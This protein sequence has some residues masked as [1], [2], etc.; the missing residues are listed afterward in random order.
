M[1]H[2]CILTLEY[3]SMRDVLTFIVQNQ[4]TN[5]QTNLRKV[6]LDNCRGD[7]EKV[8]EDCIECFPLLEAMR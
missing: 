6:I 3:E 1:S 4:L 7:M 5:F 8:L 2:K